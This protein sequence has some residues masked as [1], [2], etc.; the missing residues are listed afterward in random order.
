MYTKIISTGKYLPN[1]IRN[2]VNLKNIINKSNEWIINRT[3]I[4]ERRIAKTNETVSTMGS[5]AAKNAIKTAGLK[6]NDIQLIIVATTSSSHA[7]P[8][9]ACIIQNELNIKDCIS[10]DIAAAC[11]GFIYALSIADQYIKNKFIKYALIIGSDILTR[12]LKP[13][14]KRTLILF[15]DGAGAVIL[16]NSKQPGIIST[17]LHASGKDGKLLTLPYQKRNK[18]KKISWLKM[19]G[20]EIFKIAINKSIKIIKETLNKNNIK[21]QNIDWLIPH[22]SNIRII[23]AIVKKIGIDMNKVIITLDKHGN[24]SSASIPLALNKAINNGKIKSNNLVIFEAF[25]AGITWGSA[26]IRF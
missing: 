12:T 6:N 19:S 25:G 16:S 4:Y 8:S 22:Q 15:G 17:H 3:G 21:H 5:M 23:N 7:F 11:T 2:N 14:D 9:S 10:F 1:K 18:R 20:N 13:K 26:L 24:T